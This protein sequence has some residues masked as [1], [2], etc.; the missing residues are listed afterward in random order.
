MCA[1][2]RKSL[3]LDIVAVIIAVIALTVS[4]WSVWRNEV[5]NRKSV[6]PFLVVQYDA[7]QKM[8]TVKTEPYVRLATKNNGAG[9]ARIT[10]LRIRSTSAANV[11]EFNEIL[12]VTGLGPPLFVQSREYPVPY[13]LRPGDFMPIITTDEALL[14]EQPGCAR[15]NNLGMIVKALNTIS[16]DVEYES[17]YGE[18]ETAGLEP[19]VHPWQPLIDQSACK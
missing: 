6:V 7:P 12:R 3:W 11:K 1:K 18:K 9:V 10:D 4:S 13:F 2:P 17:L 16:V 5:H 15:V 8:I 14:S 19:R